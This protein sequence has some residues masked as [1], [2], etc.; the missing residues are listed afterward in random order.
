VN[1]GGA[2]FDPVRQILYA[3]VSRAI[4][5]VRLIPRDQADRMRS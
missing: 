5:I 4:H 2:A 1:W 3:N